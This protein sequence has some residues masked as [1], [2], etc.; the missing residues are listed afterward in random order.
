MPRGNAIDLKRLRFVPAGAAD[1]ERLAEMSLAIWRRHYFS[2]MLS[3]AEIKHLWQ[4]GYRPEALREQ[5]SAGSVFRWI[6]HDETSLGFLAYRHEPDAD[7]LWLSKLYVLPEYHDRGI[8]G[9]A[10]AEVRRAAIAL[11]VREVRLYVFKRNERAIRAYRRA[12]Y[13]IA[14]EDYSD[15]G[16]GF[17]YDDYV[18]SLKLRTDTDD[19]AH[20]ATRAAD[21][22]D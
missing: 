16:N 20:P 15:A 8:G 14:Y 17:F 12:G 7:R 4:R 2:D 6:E 21:G 1:A 18:M 11:G 22:T 3:L 19:T 5:M 10:L 9:C 13:E